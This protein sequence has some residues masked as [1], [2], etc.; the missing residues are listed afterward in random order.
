MLELPCR[1]PLALRLR[2]HGMEQTKET[3]RGYV[4][5]ETIREAVVLIGHLEMN[6]NFMFQRN[7][8]SSSNART[9]A[10]GT[11]RLAP[12]NSGSM[13][14][15]TATTAPLMSRTGPPLPPWVVSA[16]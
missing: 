14:A 10:D 8:A 1:S 6:T 13:A 2:E 7:P 11:P 9:F 4:R 5:A 3:G 16:S 12:P 15:L